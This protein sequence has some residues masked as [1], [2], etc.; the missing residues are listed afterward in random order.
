MNTFRL[1]ILK[2]K[3][4][5][6][7]AS[8]LRELI[9][10]EKKYL[11]IDLDVTIQ[12]VSF[13]LKFRNFGLRNIQIGYKYIYGLDGVKD[14]ARDFVPKN[15]YHVVM[16]F[17]D[18]KKWRKENQGQLL[19]NWFTHS[20]LFPGTDWIELHTTKSTF[21]RITTHELFHVFFATLRK[22]GIKLLDVMDRVVL[23]SNC[24]TKKFDFF[25]KCMKEFMYFHEADVYSKI[26]NRAMAIQSLRIHVKKICEHKESDR[27]IKG[28]MQKVINLAKRLLNLKK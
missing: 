25:G 17:Y 24:K 28:L 14:Q 5:T 22:K 19:G 3:G 21:V 10:Y 27:M 2:N 16:F 23:P 6:I 7:Y 13:N 8:K 18:S 15:I 1:L 9:A 4:A 20:P 12:E 11:N 26:G